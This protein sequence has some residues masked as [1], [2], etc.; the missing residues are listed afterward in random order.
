MCTPYRGNT[1]GPSV[2]VEKLV[3]IMDSSDE[4]DEENIGVEQQLFVASPYI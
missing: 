3:E 1:P 2:I 4:N